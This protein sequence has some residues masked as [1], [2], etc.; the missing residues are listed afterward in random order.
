MYNGRAARDNETKYIIPGKYQRFCVKT[1][2]RQTALTLEPKIEIEYTYDDG[3]RG[4]TPAILKTIG[5][6]S[7]SR[8]ILEV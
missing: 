6:I 5:K 7:F 4:K 1:N 8:I 2:I 3:G